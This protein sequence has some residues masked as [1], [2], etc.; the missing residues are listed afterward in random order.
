MVDG[1]VGY[2]RPENVRRVK[3]E[4]NNTIVRQLEK[5]KKELYPD[6]AKEQ[7]DR[8][9]EIQAQKKAQRREEDKAKK[10]EELE[11][12]RIKEERSYDRIMGD[13]KMTSNTGENALLVII[14]VVFSNMWYLM[15]IYPLLDGIE[16]QA[17][18]D[19]TAAEEFEDDFM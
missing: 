1:Q 17:T 16:M 5:T 3:I 7:Q 19:A 2:H 18:V 9:N 14:F 8:L 4:K 11:R 15:V 10:L 6:L 13:D 12:A